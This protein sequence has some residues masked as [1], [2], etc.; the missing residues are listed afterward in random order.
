MR[1]RRRDEQAAATTG[2]GAV[3]GRETEAFLSGRLVQTWHDQW[4]MVPAW[5]WLTVLAHGGPDEV[6]ALSDTATYWSPSERSWSLALS[7]LAGEIL[8]RAPTPEA[9]RD[10]QRTVLVPLELEMLRVEGGTVV[11]P[12]EL[13]CRV[14]TAV[15]DVHPST[16]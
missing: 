3:L 7:F 14:L 13:V 1:W 4:L 16:A 12:R 6:A 9:L 10:L 5:G 2:D 11:E 15:A 8:A